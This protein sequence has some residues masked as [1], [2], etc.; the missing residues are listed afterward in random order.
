MAA[1]LFTVLY[2]A[3]IGPALLWLVLIL[4]LKLTPILLAIAGIIYRKTRGP[5]ATS[6]PYAPTGPVIAP[7]CSPARTRSARATSIR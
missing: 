5:K 2:V 3:G 1:L 6:T 7:P 4:L